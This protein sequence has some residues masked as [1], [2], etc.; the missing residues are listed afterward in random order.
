M[1]VSQAGGGILEQAVTRRAR[2][3]KTRRALLGL[4]ERGVPQPQ[5]GPP[6][7]VP[8]DK[9]PPMRVPQPEEP[10]LEGPPEDVRARM[11]SSVQD[12]L[13]TQQ[14]GGAPLPREQA[15]SAAP[16]SDDVLYTR[17]IR[18]VRAEREPVATQFSRLAGRPGSPRELAMFQVRLML[19]QQLGRPPTEQEIL[20]YI[21]R[22]E[23]I[24]PS[25]PVAFEGD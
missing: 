2:L 4:G 20:T 16:P 14:T 12:F 24:S 7:V 15:V 18:R 22:P 1:P 17:E 9:R 23:M 5:Q 13:A 8:A 19:E 21:S 3:N 25:F 6:G 11:L 10:L